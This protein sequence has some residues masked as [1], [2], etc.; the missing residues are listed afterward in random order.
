VSYLDALPDQYRLILCDIWGV[1][2]DGV[3]LYPGAAERLEGW[4]SEGRTIVL[5]TNAP[6][7]A[8]AVEAQ[9]NRIGLPRHAWDAITTSGE[10]GI[11]AL[12]A[13]GEPVG[14]LGT[15]EDRENLAAHGVNFAGG[16]T[17][18]HLAC[19]GLDDKRDSVEQYRS[20]LEAW[21]ARDVVLHCLNPDRIVMRGGVS[22]PCAG[23]LADVYEGLGGTVE[24]YGKPYP[25]IYRHA[26]SLG[27]NP[28][29]ESVVAIGDALQTD[30]LGA[31]RMGFDAIF[32]AGGIHRGET[33]P[34]DFAESND[35]G[36]WAPLAVVDGLG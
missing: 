30:M 1:V 9:L 22:E 28:P 3:S 5:I 8:D 7:P 36:R 15:R 20:Q 25:A 23:A 19:T 31:A 10:A 18:A 24:W 14:F 11:A 32:V 17:F 33:F 12:N 4:R 16:E 35:I 27:G 21:A 6:R 26:L 29:A 34:A 2:H 13:L